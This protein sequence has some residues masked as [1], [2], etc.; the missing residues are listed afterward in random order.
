[1]NTFQNTTP[2]LASFMDG[3]IDYAGLFPPAN[4]NLH[5]TLKNMLR[6]QKFAENWMISSLVLP[7]NQLDNLT[8]TLTDLGEADAYFPISFVASRAESEKVFFDTLNTDIKR[9]KEFD[10]VI[11]FTPFTPIYELNIKFI[12]KENSGWQILIL[13]K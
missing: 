13:L 6:G 11:N 5:D 12:M 9:I 3:I 1:M 7:V 2:S 4:L 8:T 10:N